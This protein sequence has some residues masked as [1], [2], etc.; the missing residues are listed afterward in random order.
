MP[1]RDLYHDPVRSALGKDGWT[2]TDDPFT[3]EFDETNLFADL[4]AEKLLSA[5]KANRRIVVE[6][7]VFTG[8][9]R[10]ADLEFALGQYGLYRTV[11]K[12]VSPDR[13][14]FMAIAEDIY[15][16]FFVRDAV[17]AVVEDH[18]IKLLVFRP[19][20]EEIVQWIE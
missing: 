11:L 8:P 15:E 6:I 20:D 17:R 18:Q 13:K 4:A 9:S 16:D 14:L 3:M 12:R 7:K 5:E 2:I 10:I 19:E 1:A